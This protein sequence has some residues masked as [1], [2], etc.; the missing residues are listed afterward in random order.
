MLPFTS[1]EKP[2]GLQLTDAIDDKEEKL[3]PVVAPQED[4]KEWEWEGMGRLRGRS[5]GLHGSENKPW[6]F[7]VG[8][9]RSWKIRKR[10]W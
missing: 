3:Q 10:W 2:D 9:R 5:L 8:D 4:Q 6:G 7:E 1:L